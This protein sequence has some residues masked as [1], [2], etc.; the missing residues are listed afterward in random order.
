MRVPGA[1]R[2]SIA[3]APTTPSAPI[4]RP[5]SPTTSVSLSCS[6]RPVAL[7]TMAPVAMAA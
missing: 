6:V 2:F 3:D 5:V 4:I 1:L 7:G